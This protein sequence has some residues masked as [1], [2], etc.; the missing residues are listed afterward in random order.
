MLEVGSGKSTSLPHK[1]NNLLL[2]GMPG[3]GKSA[4]GRA[5]AWR[6]GLGVFDLDCWIEGASGEKITKI[7]EQRGETYFRDIES[8]ALNSLRAINNHV[9]S[10][11]GGTLTREANRSRI[12]SLGICIWLNVPIAVIASRLLADPSELEKRPFFGGVPVSREP[13][14]ERLQ[15]LWQSRRSHY[16]AC[17]H[18]E[19]DGRARVGMVVGRIVEVLERSLHGSRDL[20][21]RLN[22]ENLV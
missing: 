10:V 3:C 4:V 15:Q 19:V 12:L 22:K 17:S 6:L 2:I 14:V 5:L 1:N 8:K 13:I 18:V 21:E 11:G 9:V 7:V 20:F 16:A